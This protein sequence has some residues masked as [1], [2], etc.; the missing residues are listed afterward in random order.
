MSNKEYIVGWFDKIY[1]TKNNRD[2]ELSYN[3]EDEYYHPWKKYIRYLLLVLLFSCYNV[4]LKAWPYDELVT[5]FSNW[6]L[7]ITTLSILMTLSCVSDKNINHFER[8]E[9]RRKIAFTHLLY[10]FSI[11]FNIIVVS[12]YWPII[13]P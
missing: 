6:T 5:L 7:H 1:D 2:L 11:I 8:Y 3:F 13:H 9:I 10:T 12:L 4:T